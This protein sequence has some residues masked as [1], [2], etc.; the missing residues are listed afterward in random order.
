MYEKPQY[1]TP[2]GY[3]RSGKNPLRPSQLRNELAKRAPQKQ[4]GK[5]LGVKSLSPEAAKLI[6]EA[7]RAMLHS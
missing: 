6:A 2:D 5:T 4:K 1:L 7:I 3:K